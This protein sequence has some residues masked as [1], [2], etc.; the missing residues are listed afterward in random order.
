MKGYN[1]KII[2]SWCLFIIISLSFS[3]FFAI[4]TK[5]QFA[6]YDVGLNP[7]LT[8]NQP[9]QT[10]NSIFQALKEGVGDSIAFF[11][12]N[13]II[14]RM[15]TSVISWINSGFQGSP[16]FVTDPS[17]YYKNIGDQIAGQIIFNH[18]DLRLMCSSLRTKV[19]IALTNTY[20][21]PYNYQCTLGQIERNFDGFMNDFNQ[22][23]WDGFI[24]VSQNS[25]NN[26]LGLYNS[27]N[28]ERLNRANSALQ[29]KQEELGWGKG[30]MSFETC[31][32]YGVSTTREVTDGGRFEIQEDGS[33]KFIPATTRTV[34]DP[35]PC[36]GGKN[37]TTPGS[38]IEG[39]LSDVLGA[40]V[41]RLNIADEINEI[42][43]ALLNQLIS[44]GLGAIGKGLGSLNR[45]GSGSN[46]GTYVNQL[47]YADI[48]D[49]VPMPASGQCP[50][51]YIAIS[52][53]ECGTNPQI[54]QSIIDTRTAQ[55]TI[56]E[57][58]NPPPP[59]T[60]PSTSVTPP[61]SNPFAPPTPL[62]CPDG[63]ITIA[64]A[65]VI[66][67]GGMAT[68]LVPPDWTGGAISS[69]NLS[70]ASVSDNLITGQ[71]V[72]TT[73]ITAQGF[74]APNGATSCS[75]TGAYVIVTAP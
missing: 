18:P 7:L 22:G 63:S 24:Q 69:T 44:K 74:R 59:G 48:T 68:A 8:I 12:I 27:W 54:R 33:N 56:T 11:I 2:V 16:A 62:V 5:A 17:S 49:R 26:P 1:K 31:A 13:M 47:Q 35:P 46:G 72:G 37:I 39:K 36:I 19:Q 71:K 50:D 55:R 20:R 43:S 28:S 32:K 9:P 40:G 14:Q 57:L 66:K 67:V 38:V 70:V 45:P 42:I 58:Q 51:Y 60:P 52:D 75:L 6:T 53:S 21:Q 65:S 3:P 64:P 25:Q 10:G 41:N 61:T 29:Q 34:T 30:F 23:G 4:K 73:Y 15:T